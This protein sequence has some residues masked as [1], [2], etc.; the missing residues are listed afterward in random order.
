[1][2]E[3][4]RRPAGTDNLSTTNQ[5]RVSAC[6]SQGMGRKDKEGEG[7]YDKVLDA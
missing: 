2:D 5:F 7:E 6:S 3:D 1:M 4:I